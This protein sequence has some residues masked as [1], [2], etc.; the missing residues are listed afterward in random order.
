MILYIPGNSPVHK[1]DARVKILYLV[2]FLL[3]LFTKDTLGVIL[4]FSLVTLLLYYTSGISLLRP[5]RDLGSSWLLLLVPILLHLL[6]NPSLGLYYGVVSSLFL[7]NVILLSLLNVYT[8]EIKSLLQ[9]LVFLKVPSELAF[10]LVISLRFL[11]L[12]QEQ[13][14]KIRVSQAL[15]GYE[16]KPFSLPIPLIVPLMHSSLKRAM[17]LAISLES[18]GF[19]SE[20]INIAMELQLSKIDYVLLFLL[21][22]MVFAVF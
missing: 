18:R 22:L 20:H 21:P 4:P 12:M 13:L 14:T 15:R 2:F 1:A 5:V 6:V 17:Q 16:T 9:A 7:L 19:D 10:M 8:T 3:I 11:P